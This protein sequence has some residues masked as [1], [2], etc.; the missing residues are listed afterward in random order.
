MFS[1]PLN[2]RFTTKQCLLHTYNVRFTTN[3]CL[4]SISKCLKKLFAGTPYRSRH[5][6]VGINRNT[7][8]ARFRGKD[9]G[10]VPSEYIINIT[11]VT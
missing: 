1:A 7:K 2:V 3:Q 5:E 11:M 9:K 10:K 6:V 8:V 4:L